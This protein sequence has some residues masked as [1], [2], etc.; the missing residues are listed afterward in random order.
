MLAPG[1]LLQG[2]Y[3]IDRHLQ[4]GG[5]SAVYVAFDMSLEA[6]VAVK[7]MRSQYLSPSERVEAAKQFRLEA[8]MVANL[9]HP[10]LP[11]VTNYFEAGETSYLVMDLIDGD[12]ME[13]MMNR[14]GKPCPVPLALAWVYEVAQVLDYLHTKTPPVIFRDLKPSN[15]MVT[16]TGH[17]KLID[18]GI[19]KVFDKDTGGGTRTII[20]GAGTPGYAPPE[21]YGTTAKQRTDPRSDIYALGATLYT[22]L[23]Y[24][25]PP[26]ATDRWMNQVPLVPVREYNNT[27]PQE[28]EAAIE[29]M[30]ALKQEDRPGSVKDVMEDLLKVMGGTVPKIELP[31]SMLNTRSEEPVTPVVAVQAVSTA[32]VPGSPTVAPNMGYPYAPP[33]G[34][35]P[36]YAPPGYPPPQY[37]P[38]GYPVP[39]GAP[40]TSPMP[41]YP[42][43]QPQGYPPP[44]GYPP[45]AGYPPPGY[46]PVPMPPQLQPAPPPVQPQTPSLQAATQVAPSNLTPNTDRIELL[47]NATT[48]RKMKP[49]G[50]GLPMGAIIGGVA[51]VAIC[52]TVGF[53]VKHGPPQPAPSL[54]PTSPVAVT[55]PPTASATPVTSSSPPPSVSN[56]PSASTTLPPSINPSSAKLT[57]HFDNPVPGASILVD[58]KVV[59]DTDGSKDQKIDMPDGGETV[60][61]RMEGIRTK[62]RILAKGQSRLSFQ[63]DRMVSFSSGVSGT[64]FHLVGLNGAA[65]GVHMDVRSN[66]SKALPPGD[67]RVTASAP[68]HNDAKDPSHRFV[69]AE[70]FSLD[71]KERPKPTYTPPPETPHHYYTPIAPPPRPRNTPGPHATAG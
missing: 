15:I 35:Q 42:T 51:V 19:S 30:M 48:A 37:A 7:E 12:S 62:P 31:P 45:Q 6:K 71:P 66:S 21:Q 64:T 33:T 40:Q 1:S 22:I 55:T 63:L 43:V 16:G 44:P 29:Q 67:Y 14:W 47:G 49:Q 18:F 53:V 39:Y 34:Q 5:M 10:G 69:P 61:V 23:A 68:D 32:Q 4:D 52:A 9:N 60:E 38:P 2:R 65:K 17:I 57:L 58:H 26:E 36:Y 11:R 3:R 13:R 20:K 46:P 50:G 27:I 70:H 8:Q 41:Y 28:I 24:Q 56:T 54:P 25:I 59:A